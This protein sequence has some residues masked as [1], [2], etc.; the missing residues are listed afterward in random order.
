V[1]NFI[2]A[3]TWLPTEPSPPPPQKSRARRTLYVWVALMVFFWFVYSYFS[4]SPGAARGA[5][6]DQ[7]PSQLWTWLLC[8]G[9]FALPTVTFLWMLGGSRRYNALQRP[10]FEALGDGQNARAA[11]LFSDIARRYRAKPNMGPFAA[12]NHAVALLRAGDSSAAVGVLLGIERWPGLAITGIR[13]LVAIE[14]AV[15]FAIGGD[16]DKAQRWLEAARERPADF[17]DPGLEYAHVAYAEGLVLCRAGKFE[18][19]IRVYDEAWQRLESR[20]PVR[21]MRAVWLLRAFAVTGISAPRDSAAAESWLRL[22]RATPSGSFT[23]LTA[24][25]PELAAFVAHDVTLGH[26]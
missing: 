8:I 14:L 13:R 3:E 16:V 1:V 23:W 12:Y 19:A 26:S 6:R 11:Q 22:L 10:A 15:A 18:D 5:H 9:A 21:T 2:M 4:S 7:D 17:S 25:W 24:H 20:L